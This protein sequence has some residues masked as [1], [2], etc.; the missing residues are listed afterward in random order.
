[1]SLHELT[2]NLASY[3]LPD[4]VRV[5]DIIR[6]SHQ[7]DHHV[8]RPRVRNAIATNVRDDGYLEMALVLGYSLRKFNPWIDGVSNDLVLLIPSNTTLL[9]GGMAKAEAVGWK[10][11][12]EDDVPINGIEDLYIGFQ[13]NFIKYRAWT[14][15]DYRKVVMLD[16][17]T[18]CLGD[19]SLLISDG[20]GMSP[21]H[22]VLLFK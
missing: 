9:P 8:S 22:R 17:D 6:T 15:T 11:R 14:W 3:R 12:H 18:V 10:F 7:H 1:M 20:F 2:V 13:R 19:I 5:N 4:T 16:A 21:F